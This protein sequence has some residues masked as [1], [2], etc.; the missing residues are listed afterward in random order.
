MNFHIPGEENCEEFF[1]DKYL[2]KR[3]TD[4]ALGK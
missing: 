4:Y 1:G 3:D 2:R